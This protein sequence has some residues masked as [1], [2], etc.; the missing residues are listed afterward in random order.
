[1]TALDTTAPSSPALSEAARRFLAPPRFAVV[2][3]LNPDGS[4]LQA[5]VWY[6]LEGDTIVFNSRI[7]R[8]WPGNLCRDRRVSVT[9]ADG[10][11]Y[12][13]ARGEVEIDD[14]PSVGLAV[15]SALTHRY[16][17]DA[18]IA[19]AQIAGFAREHR[20]TF[21]LRPG[22]VFERLGGD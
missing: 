22:H 9:V 13:D 8:Q 15:I 20:V 18:A 3:T 6:L 14:D 2:A 11:Q 5:V 17:P 10:Y 21:R 16:Q 12:L 19:A 1:M 7:G 4:P